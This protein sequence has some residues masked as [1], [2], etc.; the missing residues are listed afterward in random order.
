MRLASDFLQGFSIVHA[1]ME[2]HTV[3]IACWSISHLSSQESFL[4]EKLTTR[5][6]WPTA[7]RN[8]RF[9]ADIYFPFFIAQSFGCT[10]R[11]VESERGINSPA[12]GQTSTVSIG[13]YPDGVN[14]ATSIMYRAERRFLVLNFHLMR[15]FCL[16]QLRRCSI[17]QQ[18]T[19]IRWP[20]MMAWMSTIQFSNFS[21]KAGPM[22]WKARTFSHSQETT[23]GFG[24]M[25]LQ[26]AKPMALQAGQRPFTLTTEI[27]R[28][29]CQQRTGQPLL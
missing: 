11:R 22:I 14:D 28:T 17:R 27:I 3:D 18:I 2:H 6:G 16:F 26:L 10:C 20:S 4:S 13:S 5:H 25:T 8:C 23:F 15:V 24:V 7:K 21:R 1:T 19:I 12:I 29:I 9:V